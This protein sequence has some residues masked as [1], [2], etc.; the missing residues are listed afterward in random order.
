[1]HN[2]KFMSV[3]IQGLYKKKMVIYNIKN[4]N[5]FTILM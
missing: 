2:D 5:L 3:I 1:M 4:G